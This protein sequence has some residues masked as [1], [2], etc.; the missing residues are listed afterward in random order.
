MKFKEFWEKVDYWNI[1]KLNENLALYSNQ[2]ITEML[3]EILVEDDVF[4]SMHTQGKENRWTSVVYD[5]YDSNQ[6]IEI[7]LNGQGTFELYLDY[8]DEEGLRVEKIHNLSPEQTE[9]LPEGLRILMH[10]AY[11]SGDSKSVKKNVLSAKK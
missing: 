7:R 4:I 8:W 3:K 1:D 5:W 2:L 6:Q 11:K 9:I 10:E